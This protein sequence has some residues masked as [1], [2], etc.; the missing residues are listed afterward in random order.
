MCCILYMAYSCEASLLVGCSKS[1]LYRPSVDLHPGFLLPM[2]M[3]LQG[4]ILRAHVRKVLVPMKFL[5]V[6]GGERSGYNPL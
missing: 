5:W 4:K 6:P 2:G 1:H 3:T